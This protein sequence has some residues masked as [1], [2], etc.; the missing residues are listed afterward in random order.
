MPADAEERVVLDRARRGTGAF[1]S[2]PM[3]SVRTISGRPL[4]APHHRRQ[5]LVLLVL[6][7]RLVAA[8]E[9][10]LGAHQPDALGAGL[11]GGGRLA[12]AG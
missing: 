2:P 11:D 3:S 7:R 12:R 4:S 6:A 9:Q 5:R 10:E 8:E 1:L